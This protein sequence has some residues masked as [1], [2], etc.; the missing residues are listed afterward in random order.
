MIH[1]N[2]Q[3]MFAGADRRIRKEEQHD[4]Q[5]SDR[6]SKGKGHQPDGVGVKGKNVHSSTTAEP[7]IRTTLKCHVASGAFPGVTAPSAT[8]LVVVV[9]LRIALRR[10]QPPPHNHR[11]TDH[12]DRWRDGP[13]PQRGGR[14]GHGEDD[15]S[16]WFGVCRVKEEVLKAFGFCRF[17]SDSGF[18][19]EACSV[20]STQRLLEVFEKNRANEGVS[21]QKSRT[22][23][24]LTSPWLTSYSDGRMKSIQQ[25]LTIFGS[26]LFHQSQDGSSVRS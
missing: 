18:F 6:Q 21:Q 3:S 22:S 4:A 25:S 13:K 8:I 26:V 17:Q 1:G 23:T 12:R 16:D 11:R 2:C 7:T 5:K 10:P 24:T 9:I 14:D 19:F 15:R 20:A